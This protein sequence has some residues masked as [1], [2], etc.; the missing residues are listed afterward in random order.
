MQEKVDEL[1]TDTQSIQVTHKESN[2]GIH[3]H[4]PKRKAKKKTMSPS[5]VFEEGEEEPLKED[6]IMGRR[7]TKTR[8]RDMKAFQ[9]RRQGPVSSKERWFSRSLYVKLGEVLENLED[10][11]RTRESKMG[12]LVDDPKHSEPQTMQEKVD[13]LQTDTRSIQVTHKESN[14]GIHSHTPKR[15]AKKKTMSPSGVFEE[16]EEE[17]LKED[18][19]MERR[20]T[21]TRRRDMKDFQIRRQGP[22]SSKERWF[23]RSLYVKLGEVLENLEDVR[24]TRES[25]MGK[26]VDDPKHSEPQTMQEKVD[27]LQTDTRSIQVTHKE[28]NKGIHS[29]T[30]KRKAKKKTMSPSGVFEEGEEEPLKEDCIM[31]RRVTKTRRRDMKDFQIRRQGPVSSKERWFSRLKGTLEFINLQSNFHGS[32]SS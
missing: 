26:L 31:E 32:S 22:V 19:I 9:I 5:G 6:C 30:P 3:S 12:K 10:V 24:R 25:K 21:K 29:H 15:K 7:V 27:E 2:S 14:K 18:C 17:P 4:T 13:E 11:R 28:S 8:R 20:V 23:S 16:G 1:Q